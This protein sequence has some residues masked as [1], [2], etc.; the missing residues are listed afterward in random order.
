MSE[1]TYLVTARKYRPQLFGDMVSQEHVSETLKNAIRLDRLA[2]AYMFAGPRGV[3]KTTAAR[4]LAKAVNCTTPL[5]DRVDGAEPCRTCESCKSFEEGRNLNILEI[6]AAS[7]NK[8]DDARDLRDTV[9]IPPQGAKMKIYI[10]DEVHMLTTSAFNALLKTLEEPPPYVSFIFATTEPQKVLP[11]IQSRC[12]RFDFRRIAIPEII[13]RLKQICN[14]EKITSDEASLMLIARK[15][16]GALRD[17]LSVF[18]QAVSLC[19]TELVIDELIKALGVVDTDLYFD[20]TDAAETGD[21][22]RVI[23]IVEQI[24]RSG[25]DLQ[26]FLDGLAEHLRNLLVIKT[27]G[28]RTL[29]EAIAEVQDRYEAEANRFT[30]SVLLRYV[31]IVGETADSLRNTRQPRLRLEM[32]LLK[33]ASLPSAVDIKTALEK[34]EKL[35]SIAQNP[36]VFKSTDLGVTPAKGKAVVSIAGP[37]KPVEN[38]KESAPAKSEE[39]PTLRE[40]PDS[41]ES[42][43]Q[44]E[45]PESSESAEASESAVPATDPALEPPADS[46]G[47]VPSSP[48]PSH[49]P[50]SVQVETSTLGLPFDAPALKRP[51]PKSKNTFSTESVLV[52]TDSTADVLV[53]DTPVEIAVEIAREVS[54]SISSAWAQVITDT[55]ETQIRLGSLLRHTKV[56][57]VREGLIEIG[58]PDAFH[59]RILRGD[60]NRL[61]KLLEE[62]A[63]TEIGDLHFVVCE[64]IANDS[65][66]S[67]RS[68]FDARGFLQK[69]C[70]E[71]PAVQSLVERF[72]GEIVW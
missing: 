32:A 61:S 54:E 10:I 44:S 39:E 53:V 42:A 69:K 45:S 43:E 11:T 67:S 51:S 46:P 68:E 34:I 40:E 2:H 14:E 7:N 26:E 33:M 9:R 35:E 72:G 8:V 6:D 22:G 64:D 15:G 24:V 23:R 48:A 70:E 57:T 20:V 16:D 63:S 50:A 5:E 27:V 41:P 56:I 21:V 59:E 30:E 60:R 19:G 25:Y 4:I 66:T 47:Q 65:D 13:S 3:G 58:V 49:E 12:Q 71:N 52:E 29:L 55:M 17:A 31:H 18:D 62:A 1:Q 38:S 36:S 28:D 37:A